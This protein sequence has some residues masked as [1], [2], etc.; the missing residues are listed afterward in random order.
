MQTHLAQLADVETRLHE[1]I[2]ELRQQ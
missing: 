1:A 2:R